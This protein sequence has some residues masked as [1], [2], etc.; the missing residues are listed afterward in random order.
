MG[1]AMQ[2][3]EDASRRQGAE[4]EHILRLE[5]DNVR[6][7]EAKLSEVEAECA[8]ARQRCKD[9]ESEAEDRRRKLEEMPQSR[10]QQE[11]QEMQLQLLDAERR[12]EALAASRDHF[13]RKVEELCR[14]LL[15]SPQPGTV[16]TGAGAPPMSQQMPLDAAERSSDEGTH[17]I[18][19]ALRKMQDHLADLAREWGSPAS[20]PTH[21]PAPATTSAGWTPPAAPHLHPGLLRQAVPAFEVAAHNAQAGA[22]AVGMDGGAHLEWLQGQREELLQSGLYSEGD[23][24]L[25]AIDARISEVCSPHIGLVS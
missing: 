19:H 6:H 7:L 14:R 10:M 23:P 25:R 12:C 13:R 24:V 8:A 4:A 5:R 18:T 21:S 20:G 22:E 16:H 15:K 3:Q 9:V 11:L 1:R 2:E 17:E